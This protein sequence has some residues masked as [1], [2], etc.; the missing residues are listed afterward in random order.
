MKPVKG[1]SKPEFRLFPGIPLLDGPQV[2]H[3]PGIDLCFFVAMGAYVLAS[4]QVTVGRAHAECGGQGEIGE[5]ETGGDFFDQTFHDVHITDFFAQIDVEDRSAGVSALQV[6]LKFKGFKNIVRVVDRQLGGVG[7]K[8]VASRLICRFIGTHHIR[9]CPFVQHGQSITGPFRRRGFQVEYVAGFR[10][11]GAEYVPHKI[12][13]FK[14]KGASR[15]AADVLTHEIQAGFVH[16]DDADGGK[17]I[18]PVKA[19]PLLDVSQ[20]KFRI[21]IE[22]L[23]RKFFQNFSF[24]GE[25]FLGQEDQGSE[26]FEKIGFVPG[27]IADTGHVDCYDPD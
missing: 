13:G 22:I 27:Q 17:V 23:F 19:R 18:L 10:L 21:G 15:F 9:V 20:I 1:F 2:S 7:V 14:G 8:R 26:T 12:K 4:L 5:F 11:K 16:A 24:D 25:A 6:I 3:D